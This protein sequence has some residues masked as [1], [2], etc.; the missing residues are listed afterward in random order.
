MKIITKNSLKIIE[1]SMKNPCHVGM[2]FSS[3]K[4]KKKS[5]KKI[6][7]NFPLAKKGNYGSTGGRGRSPYD[8]GLA[9]EGE[10]LTIIQVRSTIGW[11]GNPSGAKTKKMTPACDPKQWVLG[12]LDDVTWTRVI[13]AV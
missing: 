13:L 1:K 8:W 5:K 7:R 6:G 3:I 9:A 12:D 2:N 10:A 4:N 11:A